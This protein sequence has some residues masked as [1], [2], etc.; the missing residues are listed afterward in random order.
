[1]EQ[2]YFS[3]HSHLCGFDTIKFEGEAGQ[4]WTSASLCTDSSQRIE[5]LD[6]VSRWTP[7]GVMVMKD[8][9]YFNL[10]ISYSWLLILFPSKI[11]VLDLPSQMTSMYMLPSVKFSACKFVAN[12]VVDLFTTLIVPKQA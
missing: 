3:S 4:L 7:A 8:I 9:P 5:K 2:R 10:G 12:Q 6:V 11:F 1:M